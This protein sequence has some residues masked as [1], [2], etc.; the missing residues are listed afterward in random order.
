[1]NSLK[2]LPHSES[3]PPV[4]FYIPL[5]TARYS[6]LDVALSRGSPVIVAHLSGQCWLLDC[7][8]LE[9]ESVSTHCVFYMV[10]AIAGVTN[11]VGPHSGMN[12]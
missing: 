10:S 1:M 9:N 11:K 5:L 7:W 4:L 2:Q 3:V 12:N 8:L 6:Q